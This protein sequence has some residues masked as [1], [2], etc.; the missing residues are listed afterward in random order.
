MK[1]RYEVAQPMTEKQ[2]CEEMKIKKNVFL[3]SVKTAA[4]SKVLERDEKRILSFMIHLVLHFFLALPQ[5]PHIWFH[6]YS[7]FSTY[8]VNL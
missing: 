8:K 5:L 6:I 1:G 7:L 3:T 2:V 4:L